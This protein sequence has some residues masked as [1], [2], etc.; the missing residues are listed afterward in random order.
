MKGT[1]LILLVIASTV[2]GYQNYEKTSRPITFRQYCHDGDAVD[3]IFPDPFPFTCKPGPGKHVVC[4]THFYDFKNTFKCPGY[5]YV[6]GWEYLEGFGENVRC[7]EDENIEYTYRDCD[8]HFNDATLFGR[9]YRIN[10]GKVIVGF[11]SK[12][13]VTWKN[14][15]CSYRKR[16]TD[17]WG[18]QDYSTFYKGK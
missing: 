6:S 18:K 11:I 3:Q 17:S 12:D 1:G 10:K 8:V 13:G 15:E 2:L 16:V 9:S 5:G 14:I 4:K 7:C